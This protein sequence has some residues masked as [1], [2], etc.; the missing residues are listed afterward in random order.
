[1][2]ARIK[3]IDKELPL[4]EYKTKGAVAFD[5]A[6]R[7]AKTI[8]PK[9]IEYMPL[10]VCVK[11]PAGHM[12]LLAGRSSLHKR[13]L[14]MVNGVGVGDEDF[15]GN[16]D[17]YKAALYNFTDAPVALERGERI[18]QGMF[19]PILRHEWHEVDDME[20]A[21]RGGFGSTGKK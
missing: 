15:C 6:A 19:V 20:E 18:V 4:P 12:L 13:G 14:M 7:E 10:N 9:A 21:D 3:R 17:E 2:K 11:P 5:F 8:A 16:K 1:M